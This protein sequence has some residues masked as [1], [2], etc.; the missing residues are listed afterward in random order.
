MSRTCR[1]SE[2]LRD[3]RPPRGAIPAV[4]SGPPGGGSGRSRPSGQGTGLLL[5][6]GS[7]EE[8]FTWTNPFTAGERFEMIDRALPGDRGR[9]VPHRPCGRHSTARAVGALPGIPPPGI[10]PGL[11]E[12]PAHPTPVRTGWLHRR[13]SPPRGPPS[14]RGRARPSV[15][16]IGPR[17]EVA[18]APAGRRVPQLDRGALS[19][20]DA[21]RPR[22]GS[23]PERDGV[24]DPEP[25]PSPVRR[26]RFE[27]IPEWAGVSTRVVHVG[28]LPDLNA[29]GDL[30]P[31]L[32]DFDVP[33]PRRVL[34][35]GPG[36]SRPSLYP[37]HQPE[38]RGPGRGPAGPRRG[39]GGPPV[40]LG[41]GGHERGPALPAEERRR[42]GR[43]PGPVRGNERTSST[44]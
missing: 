35:S 23:A 21:A 25:P 13:A 22:C 33:V 16:G 15:P 26:S 3:A 7:A 4:P 31:D 34:G 40:R 19:T 27:P 38:L 32:P 12:Q 24:T 18:R 6:I 10:R 2:G 20:L 9:P 5:A 39:R 28:R 29:R 11:H 44:T 41:D 17:L 37:H 1:P 8:S 30:G 14:L 36:R 42:G 43:P